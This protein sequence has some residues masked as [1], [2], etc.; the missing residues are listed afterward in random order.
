MKVKT[1]LLFVL[2]VAVACSRSYEIYSN[3]YPVSFSCNISKSPFN[4]IQTWGYF[5]SVRSTPTK[6]GYEVKE[7]NGS[8]QTF[9]YTEV[10]NRVFNFGLAGLIIGKPYFGDDMIY[11]YD[12]GCPQCKRA[13]AYL[14]V[15]EDC[16]AVCPK[17]NN[18]Y[19]LNNGGVA[20]TGNS[21]PLYRYRT[22]LSGNRLMVH[23]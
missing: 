21:R 3:E 11:A 17:C 14:K 7:P 4:K 22:A 20:K 19:D 15:K 2:F 6:N 12:L 1:I 5:L 9:P 8:S 18:S 10:Q 16:I 23:N 13:S